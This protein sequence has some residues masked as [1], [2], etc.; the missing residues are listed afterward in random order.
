MLSQ[1]GDSRNALQIS[2]LYSLFVLVL[3][4]LFVLVAVVRDLC[5]RTAATPCFIRCCR[6]RTPCLIFP[7]TVSAQI[8]SPLPTGPR[9][10]LVSPIVGTGTAFAPA[11]LDEPRRL[12]VSRSLIS[13]QALL[14][15]GA[16]L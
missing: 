15:V 16:Y 2:Y 7:A 10:P 9:Q 12:R 3:L 5:L 8:E 1:W 14:G 11:K 6:S 4:P 13:I